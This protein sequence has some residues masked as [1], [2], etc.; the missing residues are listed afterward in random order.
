MA[1]PELTDAELLE[2]LEHY[3]Q[4]ACEAFDHLKPHTVHM[5]SNM[6]IECRRRLARVEDEANP[7]EWE[8]H[9]TE[10]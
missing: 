2:A 4:S 5:K 7:F 8:L 9:S 1:K 10:L 6:C 3:P